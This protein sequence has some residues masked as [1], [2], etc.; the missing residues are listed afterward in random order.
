MKTSTPSTKL[1]PGEYAL[2]IL[3][4]LLFLVAFAHPIVSRNVI[5]ERIPASAC[6]STQKNL[7]MA[8]DIYSSDNQGLYPSS[9]SS[10]APRY[11]RTLSLCPLSKMSY[12]YRI[13]DDF[14]TYTVWCDGSHKSVYP[15]HFPQ[16]DSVVGLRD[17]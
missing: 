12:C 6:K 10:L 9:L 14:K 15:P 3:I 4:G 17:R 8:L 7:S 2:S 16:Y 11:L 5:N 1:T 13:S